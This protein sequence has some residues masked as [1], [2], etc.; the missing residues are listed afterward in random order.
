MSQSFNQA[1][2]LIKRTL[3]GVGGSADAYEEQPLAPSQGMPDISHL[4]G[5][6]VEEETVVNGELLGAPSDSTEALL[7]RLSDPDEQ[8][9]H[10]HDWPEEGE[11][12]TDPDPISD[13]YVIHGVVENCGEL[14]EV[15]EA[16]CLAAT[17]GEPQMVKLES[18]PFP[19]MP[20]PE[21][22]WQLTDTVKDRLYILGRPSQDAELREKLEQG[23]T[24]IWVRTSKGGADLGYIQEGYVFLK[25]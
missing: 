3:E 8:C 14:K 5:G 7:A 9:A 21:V 15:W 10:Q 12:W 16:F 22:G 6:V 17:T 20:N 2:A 24:H 19:L 4:L 1:Q 23:E 11:L 18:G 25:K 13:G